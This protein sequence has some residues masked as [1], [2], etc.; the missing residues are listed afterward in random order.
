MNWVPCQSK[1]FL[2]VALQP[3]VRLNLVVRRLSGVL[4]VVKD[5]HLSADGLSGYDVMGLRHVPC[6][7]NLPSM[8]NLSLY[9]DPLILL[10]GVACVTTYSHYILGVVL[11]ITSV[12]RR[13]QWN[14]HLKEFKIREKINFFMTY[15]HYLHIV[16]FIIRCVCT[17][18]QLLH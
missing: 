18:K 10:L 3:Q 1:A 2:F 11:V 5:V 13:F 17:Y 9:L 7:V 16:L 8:I 6:T 12:F 15:L 4:E 14:F